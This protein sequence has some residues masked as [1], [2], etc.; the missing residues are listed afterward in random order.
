MEKYLSVHL[1]LL[2]IPIR[3]DEKDPFI[4]G[5]DS[6][7]IATTFPKTP[8]METTDSKIPSMINVNISKVL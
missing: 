3:R 5:F 8:R 7:K 1:F 6:I 2:D 4:T